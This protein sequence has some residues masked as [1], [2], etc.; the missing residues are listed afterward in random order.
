MDLLKLRNCSFRST[1]CGSLLL[2]SPS[3]EAWKKRRCL[4]RKIEQLAYVA[5]DIFGLLA[6]GNLILPPKNGLHS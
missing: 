3:K 6:D 1:S 4:L 5:L 2:C